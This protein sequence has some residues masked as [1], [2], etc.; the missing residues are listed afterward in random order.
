[1]EFFCFSTKLRTFDASSSI[2]R[3][4]EKIILSNKTIII[5]RISFFSILLHLNLFSFINSTVI[6]FLLIIINYLTLFLSITSISIINYYYYLI[7]C[8][9]E[10]NYSFNVHINLKHCNKK[11]NIVQAIILKLKKKKKSNTGLGK[12]IRISNIEL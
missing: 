4:I 1:M 2:Q 10:I 3:K 9:P 11:K 7:K 8:M 12:E 5:I 6:L